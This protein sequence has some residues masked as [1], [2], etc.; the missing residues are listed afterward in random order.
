MRVPPEVLTGRHVVLRRPVLGDAEALSAVLVTNLDHLTPWMGWAK[1][2]AITVEAQRTRL[3]G[4]AWVP[5][6]EWGYLMRDPL[7]DTVIGSC[8]LMHRRGPGTLEIGYWVHVERTGRGLATEAAGLLTGAADAIDGIGCVWILT[9][10]G[11]VR[12]AA[13]PRRLGYALDRVD[14]TAIDAPAATGRTQWWRHDVP[15]TG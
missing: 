9:D 13:V 1:P 2:E 11:N 3:A 10:E 15:A 7:D 14:D 12:S 4:Q 6:E 8:S 5:G